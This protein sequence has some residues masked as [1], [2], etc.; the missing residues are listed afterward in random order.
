MGNSAIC[1]NM[2]ESM[3][4]YAMGNNPDRKKH[5][6]WYCLFVELKKEFDLIVWWFIG[7]RNGRNRDRL[8]K[9]YKL[10]V[11]RWIGFELLMYK[12]GDYGW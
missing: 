1:G 6:T 8:V 10:L 5:T 9:G 12:C 4:H 11:I 2:D 3:D 7:P